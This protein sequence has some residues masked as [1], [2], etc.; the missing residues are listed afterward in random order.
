MPILATEV[1]RA[2]VPPCTRADISRAAA[3][4]PD[5][6]LGGTGTLATNSAP[7]E[8]MVVP[9]QNPRSG[10]VA[11]LPLPVR[12]AASIT[13]GLATIRNG[14][15]DTVLG[16]G[17]TALVPPRQTFIPA[18][19]LDDLHG[20]DTTWG[21]PRRNR[22]AGTRFS[23]VPFADSGVRG[24][25][26]AVDRRADCNNSGASPFFT[27]NAAGFGSGHV[28]SLLAARSQVRSKPGPLIRNLYTEAS[29]VRPLHWSINSSSAF[30]Q[31]ARSRQSW[32]SSPARQ[33]APG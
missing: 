30:L 33:S 3:L 32:P 1:S 21:C 11:T 22:S 18:T 14:G 19:V 28:A 4:G 9:V 12:R 27:A 7:N 25:R 16:R 29:V 31:E 10:D 24:W 6:P 17:R 15:E 20:D 13:I 23:A 5:E 2:F 8:A 26:A